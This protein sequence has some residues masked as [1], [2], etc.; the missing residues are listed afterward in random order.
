MINDLGEGVVK[1]QPVGEAL[2]VN[3]SDGLKT[4][5]RDLQKNPLT[6]GAPVRTYAPPL[7]QGGAA[8]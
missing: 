1:A 7:M 8:W 4:R 2:V 3:L 5:L 6:G